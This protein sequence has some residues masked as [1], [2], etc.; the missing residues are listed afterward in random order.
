MEM[1]HFSF[2][3]EREKGCIQR[4]ALPT[5]VTFTD[6][7]LFIHFVC[8][9]FSDS[10][11]LGSA[12]KTL[13]MKFTLGERPWYQVCVWI[14]ELLMCEAGLVSKRRRTPDHPESHDGVTQH[15]QLQFPPDQDQTHTPKYPQTQSNQA[16]G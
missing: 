2:T 3:Y 8:F 10:A 16:L 9:D 7:S 14:I 4:S 13:F 12:L 6:D 15:P 11:Q 1:Q 5:R